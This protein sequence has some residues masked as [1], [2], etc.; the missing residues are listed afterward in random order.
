[1]AVLEALRG[2]LE[3]ERANNVKSMPA[4]ASEKPN[5]LVPLD[6]IRNVI[7]AAVL[8]D[9]MR[10]KR[11]SILFIDMRSNPEN[12]VQYSPKGNC[13]VLDPKRIVKG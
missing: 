5:S 1:M 2:K 4:A 11:H 8:A 6:S 12:R 3:R 13:V 10:Q 7:D 9:V